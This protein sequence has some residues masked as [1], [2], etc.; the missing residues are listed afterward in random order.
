M[1]LHDFTID[2]S[3]GTLILTFDNCNSGTVEYDIPSINR[4]GIVQIQGVAEDNIMLC[5]AL[6]VD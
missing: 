5:Q 3:G 4:Q 6:S 1:A 2:W